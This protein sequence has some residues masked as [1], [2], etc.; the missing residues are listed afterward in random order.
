LQAVLGAGAV[1]NETNIVSVETNDFFMQKV[2]QPI[3]SLTSGT[4]NSVTLYWYFRRSRYG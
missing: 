4:T 1:T 3:I 2:K